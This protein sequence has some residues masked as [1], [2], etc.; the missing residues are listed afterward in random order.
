V[1]LWLYR[2]FCDLLLLAFLAAWVLIPAWAALG[3]LTG[4]W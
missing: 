1:T 3:Y 2:R 4:R